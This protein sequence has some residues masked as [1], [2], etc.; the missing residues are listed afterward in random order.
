MGRRDP[1]VSRRSSR[2]PVHVGSFD[3][4]DNAVSL[5]MRLRAHGYAVAII[6]VPVTVADDPL[7]SVVLGAGK[8]ARGDRY[9]ERGFFR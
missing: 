7:S 9:P 4:R 1:P 8:G 6:D 3:D 5:A 2:F